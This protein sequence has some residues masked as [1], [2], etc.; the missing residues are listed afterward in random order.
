MNYRSKFDIL[1]FSLK[2][3]TKESSGHNASLYFATRGKNVPNGVLLPFPRSRS[4]NLRLQDGVTIASK[5]TYRTG[6]R[7]EKYV[8]FFN[9]LGFS[10]TSSSR[11]PATSIKLHEIRF[12][13]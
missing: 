10:R 8:V 7:T 9:E 2:V 4:F 1:M 6:R 11:E 12:T 5:K 13:Y 3:Q